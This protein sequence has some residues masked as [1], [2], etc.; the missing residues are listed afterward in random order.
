MKNYLI[1][2][3]FPEDADNL[4]RTRDAAICLKK[5]STENPLPAFSTPGS[6]Q[7]SGWLI[8]TRLT[9]GEIRDTLLGKTR[10]AETSVLISADTVLVM[11]LGDTAA[12]VGELDAAYVWMMRHR[13]SST[14]SG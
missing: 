9:A 8:Q 1:V 12:Y 5:I 3:R 2:L 11:E 10:Y 7:L 6:F 13:L 4:S 14:G